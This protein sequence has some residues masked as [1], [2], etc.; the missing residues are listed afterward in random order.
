MCFNNFTN[1]TLT[2]IDFHDFQYLEQSSQTCRG[3]KHLSY[4]SS[5]LSLMND[6]GPQVT[7]VSEITYVH[8][9]TSYIADL[10]IFIFFLSYLPSAVCLHF[11]ETMP[12]GL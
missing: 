7:S 6:V 4:S 11:A 9:S 10:F 1:I 12:T 8:C 5:T 3:K 2:N